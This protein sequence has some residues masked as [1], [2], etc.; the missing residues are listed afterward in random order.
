MVLCS[1]VGVKTVGAPDQ[2]SLDVEGRRV[3]TGELFRCPVPRY[4]RAVFGERPRTP[5]REPSQ[6]ISAGSP[7]HKAEQ[8]AQRTTHA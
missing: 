7:V 2:T 4:E 1:L 8:A 5:S 3:A 6:Y